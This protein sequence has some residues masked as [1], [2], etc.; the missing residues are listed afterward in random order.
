MSIAVRLSGP[1]V[2]VYLSIIKINIHI[3]PHTHFFQIVW[4]RVNI[5]KNS[6]CCFKCSALKK[7]MIEMY[8]TSK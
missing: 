8:L 6:M 1:L 5:M 4:H 3:P 7:Y 2:C